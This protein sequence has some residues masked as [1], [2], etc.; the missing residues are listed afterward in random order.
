MLLLAQTTLEKLQ[1][2]PYRFWVNCG[3]VILTSAVALL[4]VRHAARMNR[5]VLALIVFLL[6]STIGFQWIWE[7]NEPQVL[8]PMINKIAP[9]LPSKPTYSDWTG[10]S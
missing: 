6:I 5:M 10:G 9:F 8:T 4:L 3:L 2:V 7:R 1:V